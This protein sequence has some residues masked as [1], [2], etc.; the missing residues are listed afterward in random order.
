MKL[1][2]SARPMS[3][4]DW[5]QLLLLGALWGGSFF[6]AR[7]AVGEIPPLAL[8]LYRVSIATLV[9]Q[10]WLRMQRVSFAPALAMPGPF[11]CLALLN[12]VFPFSLIFIGQ[13]EIGAG[14]A[15]V[16]YATTPLWTVL[17]ANA[18]TTDEKLSLTKLAGVCLG[19]AGVAVM[20]G[21]AFL[22]DLGAPVWAKLAVVGAALSYAF[23]VVYAKRFNSLNPSVVATGQLTAST[24]VMG[25]VTFLLYRPE[26]IVTSSVAILA[27]VVALAI[28]STALAFI[29]YF[30]LVL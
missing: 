19:V 15:S 23:A 26:E 10:L 20:I 12:N 18:F 6:F 29:L 3:A 2:V 24:V 28:F 8:V 14:L 21:P 16:L 13:T 11:L 30:R 7:I 9:L 27:A 22:S 5:T 4:T 25:P 17:V 1:A